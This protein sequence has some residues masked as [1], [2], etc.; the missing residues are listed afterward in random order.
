MG[1]YFL[2][3]SFVLFEY[4][5]VIKLVENIILVVHFVPNFELIFLNETKKFLVDI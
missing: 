5:K 4:L 3:F 2:G 1:Q